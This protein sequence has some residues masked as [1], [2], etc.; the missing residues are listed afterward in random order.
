MLNMLGSAMSFA[1]T[2]AI[3]GFGVVFFGAWALAV[4]KGNL[5]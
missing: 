1:T 4:L 2:F 5:N 3:S